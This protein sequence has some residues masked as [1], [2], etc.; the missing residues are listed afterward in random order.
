MKIEIKTS[1]KKQWGRSQVRGSVIGKNQQGVQIQEVYETIF[2]LWRLRLI[3]KHNFKF[4]K[5]E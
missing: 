3:I 5:Y 2:Y 4:A 1:K